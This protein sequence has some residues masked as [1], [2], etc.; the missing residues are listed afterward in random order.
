MAK[1]TRGILAVRYLPHARDPALDDI[2]GII[3]NDGR[4]HKEVAADAG[5]SPSTINNWCKGR[6]YMPQRFTVDQVLR[7]FGKKL[8][9]SD[10][11]KKEINTRLKRKKR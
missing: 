5:C 8:V 10:V 6:V 3:E 11:D 1:K 9:I 7:S 4:T 2:V